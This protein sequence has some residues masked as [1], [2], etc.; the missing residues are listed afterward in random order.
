MIMSD[1]K[2]EYIV[3]SICTLILS[4]ASSIKLYQYDVFHMVLLIIGIYLIIT[5]F[6]FVSYIPIYLSC[7]DGSDDI[8]ENDKCYT[9]RIVVLCKDCKYKSKSSVNDKG[10]LICSVSGMEIT[11]ND[12]C[13][14]S[15]RKDD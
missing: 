5:T 11:D 8:Y 15:E 9:V 13:S 10:F 6:Q 4:I 1:S 7:E 3:A 2:F 12:F 14:Y